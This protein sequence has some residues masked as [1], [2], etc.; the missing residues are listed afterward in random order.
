MRVVKKGDEDIRAL[1]GGNFGGF[2]M[3]TLAFNDRSSGG[4]A[5]VPCM[6][7]GG[8][9]GNGI[10]LDECYIVCVDVTH[11]VARS[12]TEAITHRIV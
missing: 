1:A 7:V 9:F 4:T 12:S 2:A 10:G 11:N 6:N 5:W 3:L 8:R